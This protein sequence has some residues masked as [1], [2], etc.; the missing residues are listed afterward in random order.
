VNPSSDSRPLLGL[1]LSNDWAIKN[2]LHSGAMSRLAE[3]F[4]LLAWA[5][6]SDLANI[7]A[8]AA[9][10]AVP[11]VAWEPFHTFPEATVHRLVRQAQ[12]TMFYA[13]HDVATERIRSR[14]ARGARNGWQRLAT[15][16]APAFAR[17][18]A[19]ALV[20]GAAQLLRNRIGY[21]PLYAAAFAQHRPA[22]LLTGN[23]VDFLEDPLVYEAARHGVPAAAMVASWDN[24]TGKGMMCGGFERIFV[25]NEI[26][27]REVAAFFP[28]YRQDQVTAV[29][30]PRFDVYAR[31]LPPQFARDRFLPRLQL[32]PARRVML[33]A[34][35]ATALIPEQP[36]I[37]QHI[38]NARSRGELPS[39]VQLLIRCHP[40]D[41]VEPYARFRDHG[42]V[43]VWHPALE[44]GDDVGGLP[45]ADHL[46]TLTAMIK[47][48]A[49][50]M[51]PCST[52]TLDAVMC[53][54][55]VASIAYDGDASKSYYDSILSAYDYTHFQP[56]V[57]SGAAPL[58]R[59]RAELIGALN[60]YLIDPTRHR[61]ER[62]ALANLLCL[63]DIGPATDLLYRAVL[64]WARSRGVITAGGAPP[65]AA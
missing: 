11:D 65:L 53:D 23:P 27:R 35:T 24:L 25:W 2:L 37:I 56:V 41:P 13:R 48:S 44:D 47:H 49:V 62:R 1:V 39:D 19:G 7:R 46:W 42:G 51:N 30:I 57:R 36:Q 18:R 4:R 33:F 45:D 50:S 15:W 43:A 55:P 26:M 59:S 61:S 54:V 38:L 12:R 60:A 28:E 58:C 3:S 14:S 17:S 52:M 21:R 20:L 64:S 6:A 5:P 34:N 16:A 32:D 10:L 63:A 29:G 8:M 40:R 31:P 22:L 9:S